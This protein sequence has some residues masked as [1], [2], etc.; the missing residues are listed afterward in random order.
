MTNNTQTMKSC[1][2]ASLYQKGVF[3]SISRLRKNGSNYHYIT[4]LQPTKEGK[5]SST[6]VYFG[7]KTNEL[8]ESNFNTGDSMAQFLKHAILVETSNEKGET[9]FKIST[10][11]TSNYS[12]EAELNEI[13]GSSNT[14]S[15]LNLEAFKAEFSVLSATNVPDVKAEA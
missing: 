5:T 15:E 9:R 10:S 6:N 7:K 11:E 2:L 8:V 12:S 4:L 13:W 14:Q 3:K 1:T